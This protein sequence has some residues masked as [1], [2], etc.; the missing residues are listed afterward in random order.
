MM[1]IVLE[2]VVRELDSL[3]NHIRVQQYSSKVINRIKRDVE[4]AHLVDGINLDVASNKIFNYNS[5][6]ISLYGIFERYV[7]DLLGNY[8]TSVSELHHSYD[9]LPDIIKSN[10]I[11]KSAELL[12]NIDLPKNKDLDSKDIIA[13][14]HNNISNG[15]STLNTQAFIQHKVNFRSSVINEYFKA[16][17]VYELNKK[18]CLYKPLSTLLYD[19]FGNIDNISSD[20]LFEIINDLANRRND[21]AH[22]AKNIDLLSPELLIE[23]CNFIKSYAEA[24]YLFLLDKLFLFKTQMNLPLIEKICVAGSSI[25]CCKADELILTSNSQILVKRN[26]KFPQYLIANIEGIQLNNE[27]IEQVRLEDKIN[28]GIKLDID[29]R[30]KNDFYLINK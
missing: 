30:S 3:S 4:L 29:I 16:I 8:L 22:G 10:N 1:K 11:S 27:Q 9:D 6:I 19:A 12:L 5:Y 17:G 18:I 28:I 20:K 21:V 7:E 13:A 2:T 24:L 14:L 26:N 25:L 23:Y 15:N